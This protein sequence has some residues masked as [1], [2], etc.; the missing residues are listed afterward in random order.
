MPRLLWFENV[1]LTTREIV[2]YRFCWLVFGL[3]PS[4]AI[5]RGVIQHHLLQYKGG[6]TQ[7]TQFLLVTL[8]VDDLPGGATDSEKG[9]EFYQQAKEIM[10]FQPLKVENEQLFLAKYFDNGD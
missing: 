2:Q 10:R 8:Y 3:T 7:V 5:L 4:P 9:F 6:H 1:N